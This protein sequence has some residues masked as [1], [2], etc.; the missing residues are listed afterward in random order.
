MKNHHSG[1]DFIATTFNEGHRKAIHVIT[2]YRSHVTSILPFINIL[3]QLLCQIP[4]A[5]PI[6]ILDDFNIDINK[7]VEKYKDLQILHA[8]MSKYHFKQ[9]ISISTTKSNSLI[10]HIW[11]NIPGQE[12]FFGVTD[13]Y[14]P[15]YHKPIYC[16]FK[17]PNTMPH[18]CYNKSRI[19]FNYNNK[20]LKP[21]IKQFNHVKIIEW[22][23]YKFVS[24]CTSNFQCYISVCGQIS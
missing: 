19:F 11:S 2:L 9:K 24:A 18:Y 20:L 22:F 13:A 12:T 21:T 14:W 4:L 6:V 3:E 16:A 23:T 7:E 15:N 5:C 10:N 1:S 8:C 17:L